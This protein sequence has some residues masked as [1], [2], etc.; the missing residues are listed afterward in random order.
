MVTSA[1]DTEAHG[2]AQLAVN[3]WTHL[4][5]TYDG[6][7]LRWYVGGAQNASA[8]RSYPTDPGTASLVLGQADSAG[9]NRLDEVAL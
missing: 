6:T 2:A 4:A 5:T 1:A 3:T 8:A 7:T 9:N